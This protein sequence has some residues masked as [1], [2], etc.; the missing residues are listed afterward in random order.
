MTKPSDAYLNIIDIFVIL[1]PGAVLFAAGEWIVSPP[2]LVVNDASLQQGL[3]WITVAYLLG[4]F[5]SVLASLAEDRFNKLGY[6]QKNIQKEYP[7][8]RASAQRVLQALLGD[9]TVE[10]K[11]VRRMA[12]ILLTLRGGEAAAALVARK[13][14]DRRLFRNLTIVLVLLLGASLIFTRSWAQA[15]IWVLL[16]LLAIVRFLDQNKKYSRTV[17]EHLIFSHALKTTVTKAAVATR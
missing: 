11:D 13:D 12:A 14:A 16:L 5:V 3:V 15:G 4:H 17:Y 7:E 2:G 10:V 9:V 6:R 8:L 1:L